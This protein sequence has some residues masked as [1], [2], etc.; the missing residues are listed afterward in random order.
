MISTERPS[1]EPL[2]KKEVS[3]A[4]LRGREVWKCS[5]GFKRLELSRG[6]PGKTLRVFPEIFP[7]FSRNFFRK[8]PAVRV[9]FGK[10]DFSLIFVFEPPD[11]FFADLVAGVS[12]YLNFVGKS[13]Q[14]NPPGNP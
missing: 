4:I 10:S 6:I 8:V 11:F 12:H 7:D 13:A 9:G 2:L 5:G 1:P 3:L 14:K